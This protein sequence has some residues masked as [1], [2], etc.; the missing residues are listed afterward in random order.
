MAAR[1]NLRPEPRV[2]GLTLVEVLVALV[3]LSILSGLAWQAV[4]GMVRSRSVVNESMDRS[5]RLNTVLSQWERDL[6][7]LMP[8]APVPAIHFDGVRLRLVRSV[9]Q[10]AQIVVWSV[11]DG[12]WRRWV[13]PALTVEAQLVEQWASVA[14]MTGREPG[15]VTLAS[16]VA[17]WQLYFFRGNAWS[18]AQSTADLVAANAA[19]ERLPQGVRV[20]MAMGSGG[21]T[22]SGESGMPATT[23]TRDVLV[24]GGQP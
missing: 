6:Q 5:L 20:V 15:H 23:L 10:G 7:D 19:R 18:N 8:E 14:S 4:D 12:V 3:A 21:T 1:S 13:A 24:P 11:R 16:G 2:R 17:G 22:G 9:P